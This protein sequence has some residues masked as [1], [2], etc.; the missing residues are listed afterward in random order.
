MRSAREG[1]AARC[2][3]ALLDGPD[4]AEH[5]VE[6]NECDRRGRIGEAVRQKKSAG[7]ADA[8]TLSRTASAA[9]QLQ[10]VSPQLFVSKPVEAEDQLAGVGFGRLRPWY[11]FERRHGNQYDHVGQDDD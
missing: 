1:R 3:A 6:T 5:R 9:V 8:S 7:S 4:D 2:V 11:G 10:L